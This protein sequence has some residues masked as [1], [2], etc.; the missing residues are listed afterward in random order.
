MRYGLLIAALVALVSGC[1]LA[2]GNVSLESLL[3]ERIA[4]A[5]TKAA[6]IKHP[7]AD[8]VE[9]LT[10]IVTLEREFLEE[11][12]K[13][14]TP[15]LKA[16]FLATGY[17]VKIHNAQSQL[18]RMTAQGDSDE[19]IILPL[20]DALKENRAKYDFVTQVIRRDAP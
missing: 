17:F 20:K 11:L 2:E 8:M 12:T 9:R 4:E 10:H 18:N 16:R 15:K 7:N 19:T 14:G 6:A 13:T 5:S 1:A 3:N